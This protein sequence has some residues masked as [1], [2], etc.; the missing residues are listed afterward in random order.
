MT[1]YHLDLN[2]ADSAVAQMKAPFSS[3]SGI[4]EEVLP[5]DRV[6]LEM[7]VIGSLLGKKEYPWTCRRR[8][9]I[10]EEEWT[11]SFPFQTV[12]PVPLSYLL[13]AHLVWGKGGF[14]SWY[15][16]IVQGVH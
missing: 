14:D 16:G 11:G 12:L 6:H 2:S 8:E 7:S 13:A 5:D 4:V 3:H 1:E 15:L 10:P 9:P